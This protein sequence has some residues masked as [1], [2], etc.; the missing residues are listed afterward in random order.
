MLYLINSK[1]IFINQETPNH[2]ARNGSIS[3]HKPTVTP[4]RSVSTSASTTT[5]S[6]FL[7]IH[8]PTPPVN[9]DI[10]LCMVEVVAAAVA[11]P[12]LPLVKP[13]MMTPPKPTVD[14]KP[15]VCDP[16][17]SSVALGASEM[18]VPL[19]VIRGPPGTSVCVPMTKPEA[20]FPVIVEPATVKMSGSRELGRGDESVVKSAACDSRDS[21]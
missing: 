9:G 3:Y 13:P 4:S 5:Q 12:P 21:R 15:S 1:E 16:T 7:T 10:S 2:L 8:P 14:S 11:A 19:T 6:V 20:G 18:G 17:T